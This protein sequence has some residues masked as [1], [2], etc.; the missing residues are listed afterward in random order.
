MSVS[1]SCKKLKSMIPDKCCVEIRTQFSYLFTQFILSN[2]EQGI[3]SKCLLKQVWLSEEQADVYLLKSICLSKGKTEKRSNTL[4]SVQLVV[5]L[6]LY[7]DLYPVDG[8]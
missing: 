2:A 1:P 8:E 6:I 4:L 7:I 3:K 5:P